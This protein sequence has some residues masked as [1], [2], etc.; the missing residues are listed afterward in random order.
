MPTLAGAIGQACIRAIDATSDKWIRLECPRHYPIVEALRT[1]DEVVRVGTLASAP[2]IDEISGKTLSRSPQLITDWR[3]QTSSNGRV[4]TVIVGDAKGSEE[5]GLIRTRVVELPEIV[6][7]WAGQ[8]RSHLDASGSDYQA[9]PLRHLFEHLLVEAADDKLDA[10]ELE[11][12]IAAVLQETNK[13][14]AAAGTQLWRIGL[15]PDEALL[16]GSFR[17]RLLLNRQTVDLL[18]YPPDTASDAKRLLR[19][20][21]S[22]S[23][24]AVAA[25]R[26]T[27]T[28]DLKDLARLDLMAVRKILD[29]DKPPPQTQPKRLLDLLDVKE[30]E[31]DQVVEALAE[32]GSAVKLDGMTI[33]LSSQAG[34][35]T[36]EIRF[37]LENNS[38]QAWTQPDVDDSEEVK[39]DRPWEQ[40]LIGWVEMSSQY[41][42]TLDATL[43]AQEFHSHATQQDQADGAPTYSGLVEEYVAARSK[44]SAARRRPRQRRRGSPRTFDSKR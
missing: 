22:A 3:N 10:P 24:M 25:R 12:Y 43:T 7:V 9:E 37:Y 35:A 32:L 29:G 41:P 27:E 19:L 17:A 39:F 21:Q 20:Q 13:V 34:K 33:D 44:N 16:G 6:T 36:P 42:D 28:L 38:E 5:A 15:L 40:I 14:I 4:P 30:D 8:L 23:A 26:Y 1:M 18:T 11:R 2:D 31:V